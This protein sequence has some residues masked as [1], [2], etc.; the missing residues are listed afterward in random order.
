MHANG[1]K[2][3]VKGIPLVLAGVFLFSLA[4]AETPTISSVTV[5]NDGESLTLDIV[6]TD[7]SDLASPVTVSL[8]G[9]PCRSRASSRASLRPVPKARWQ[10]ANT[11]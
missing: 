4:Y 11:C 9:A 2:R 1:M 6:G 7:L 8:G 10:R 5:S 3:L